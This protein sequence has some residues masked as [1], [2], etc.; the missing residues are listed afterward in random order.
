MDDVGDVVDLNYEIDVAQ[1]AAL[2]VR[3]AQGRDVARVVLDVLREADALSD[4]LSA[5]S[6]DA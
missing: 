2:L 4:E 5:V 1:V 3:L 6:G